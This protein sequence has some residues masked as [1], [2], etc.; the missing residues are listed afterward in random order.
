MRDA[1][2]RVGLQQD[3]TESLC[4]ALSVHSV[5]PCLFFFFP[6]ILVFPV[7]IFPSHLHAGQFG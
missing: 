5:E 2:R 1:A 4:A 6:V 3:R 7:E